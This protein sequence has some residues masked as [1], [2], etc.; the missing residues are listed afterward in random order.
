MQAQIQ[1]L[2]ERERQPDVEI[3]SANAVL[4][5]V[6]RQRLKFQEMAARDLISLSELEAHTGGLESRRRAAQKQID[7]SQT[8]SE[9]V[10][11]LKL[12]QRN[13]ILEIMGQT[14]EM[15]TD[16]YKDLHLRVET[17]R[18]DVTI[19]GIFGSQNFAPTST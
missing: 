3:K 13:P 1:T 16:Y 18:K 14:R 10:E 11:R 19:S 12:I 8:V 9:R 5:D 2:I 17:N 7:A 4:E 15:R 6:A